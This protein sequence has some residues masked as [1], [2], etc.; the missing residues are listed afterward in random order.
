MRVRSLVLM[1]LLA[2]A[3]GGFASNFSFTGAFHNDT[4]VEYFTF[5]LFADAPNVTL[6]TLSYGG[7]TN[8]AGSLISQG[9][10]DTHI[11]IFDSTGMA[12]NPGSVGP[13]AGT[14]LNADTNTGICGDVYYPTTLS[15]PGG[16]W[17]AGTYTVALTLDANPA[18]GNL[19]DGF[20]APDVLGVPTPGNFTCQQGPLGF[21]GSPATYPV[22]GPFCDSAGVP[23][24][25]AGFLRDGH[26]ALD[27]LGVDSAADITNTIPEPG[28]LSLAFAGI[29]AAI[30]RRRRAR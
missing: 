27:I 21:Q 24:N 16:T 2:A 4:D 19:G 12:M 29:V 23:Q 22:D 13:C 11:S 3:Q 30:A 6:L 20:F 25:N 1:G 17:S 10:F 28:T 14:P 5:T 7:G 18:I 9:G 8:A 26:W 15:F